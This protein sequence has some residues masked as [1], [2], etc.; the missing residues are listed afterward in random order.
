MNQVLVLAII[1]VLAA[2]FVFRPLVRGRREVSTVQPRNLNLARADAGSIAPE[3]LAELELDRAMG[4]VTDADYERWR[5]QL[6]AGMVPAEGHAD[7]SAPGPDP[8]ARAESLVRQWREV[9]RSDCPT[10]GVR[11]EPEA[12]YCSNCGTSL[13]TA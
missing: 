2:V 11:P 3:E 8:V 9:P 10:C 13:G 12:R 5:G 6:E 1:A 4:R 7:R